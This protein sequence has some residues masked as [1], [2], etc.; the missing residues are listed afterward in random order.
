MALLLYG[1]EGT[2][3]RYPKIVVWWKFGKGDMELTLHSK[4][5]AEARKEAIHMGYEPPVWYKPWQYFYGG[6]NFLTVGFPY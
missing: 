5:L 4:T 2:V 6:L 1:L 3:M